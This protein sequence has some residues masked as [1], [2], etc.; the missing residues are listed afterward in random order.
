MGDE[1]YHYRQAK[2]YSSK[3]SRPVWDPVYDGLTK[4]GY[5]FTDGPLWYIGLAALWRLMGSNS[6]F[7]A[8]I[9]H[10]VYFGIL[11]ISLY[12]L[13]QYMYQDKVAFL[14]L[15]L[16][17][18][19]PLFVVLGIVFYQDVPVT[20]LL[21]LSL[22]F[23]Y[24][25]RFFLS[26]LVF[27]LSALTKINA[28]MM[29]PFYVLLV[30]V[31]GSK[32]IP[33]IL[34]SVLTFLLPALLVNIPDA[35]F[36]Y[37]NFGYIYYTHPRYLPKNL[38]Y[39]SPGLITNGLLNIF[40]FLGVGFIVSLCLYIVVKEFQKKDVFL[41]IP[42][43]G[44]FLVF[45]VLFRKNP[46]VRYLLP[47]LPMLTI[48][49]AKGIFLFRNALVKKTVII[50]CAFQFLFTLGYVY[51]SRQLPESVKTGFRFIK[52]HIPKSAVILYP[53]ENLVTYTNRPVAWGRVLEISDLFWGE[54]EDNMLSVLKDYSIDYIAVKKSRIYDDVNIHHL[55][56]YPA[57]FVKKLPELTFL[58]LLFENE[59]LSIWQV[60]EAI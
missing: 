43:T 41:I 57:S 31:S 39:Y 22:Y 21:I 14:S 23:I 29:L 16:L 32:G 58:S 49:A 46:D 13:A 60:N 9:Y 5:C 28:I 11:L 6:F 7:A 19:I 55:G 40:K 37:E 27:G 33:D 54:S 2:L 10:L 1:S 36:R 12:L 56:G 50:I 59:S 34:K 15:I 35:V 47:I 8:Q 18:S 3:E 38:D 53:E 44:Y 48:L 52:T 26:G 17:S 30:L 45:L 20:A 51:K 25:K 24:R 4:L 42:A